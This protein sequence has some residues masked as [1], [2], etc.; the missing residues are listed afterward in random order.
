LKSGS[1]NLLEPSGPVQACKGIAL[2]SPLPKWEEAPGLRRKFHNKEFHAF[3]LPLNIP[4][5]IR[6]GSIRW[7]GNVVRMG[8]KKISER[9]SV[10]KHEGKRPLGRR[11]RR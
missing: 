6:S 1:L 7:A 9:V 2:P 3:H 10:G 5:V 8:E 11:K 4:D